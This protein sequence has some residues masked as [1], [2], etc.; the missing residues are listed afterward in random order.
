VYVEEEEAEDQELKLNHQ[1]SMQ[2]INE[3]QMEKA[4]LEADL[5]R[6]MASNVGGTMIQ[7]TNIDYTAACMELQNL[8]NQLRAQIRDAQTG[9][10]SFLHNPVTHVQSP[11][12][13]ELMRNLERLRNENNY[14]RQQMST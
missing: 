13:A 2:R 1:L 7:N 10:G 8:N 5:A 12:Q 6:L 14:L 11:R 4:R 9:R 3:L